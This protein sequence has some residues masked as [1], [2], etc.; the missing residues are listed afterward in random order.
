MAHVVIEIAPGVT[1]ADMTV[2]VPFRFAAKIDA[3]RVVLEG[4]FPNEP[5]PIPFDDF[6][7]RVKGALKDVLG[8]E[9]R[10]RN[11]WSATSVGVQRFR[12]IA[13]PAR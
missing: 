5:A 1:A 3:I 11:A 9:I 4:A 10:V 13:A 8:N 7:T 2:L 6:A 12:V